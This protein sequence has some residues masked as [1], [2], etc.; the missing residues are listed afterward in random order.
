MKKIS[1]LLIGLVLSTFVLAEPSTSVLIRYHDSGQYMKDFKKIVNSASV[2]LHHQENKNI[3]KPAIVLDID[4]TSLSNWPFLE[5]TKFQYVP[6]LMDEWINLAKSPAL[7]PTL[8]LYQYAQSHHIA[9]FFI[10][11][12]FEY[13]RAATIQNLK[14]AGYQKWAGL[15]LRPD[16][17]P[18]NESVAVYKTKARRQ[19][20]QQGYTILLNMGDQYSDLCG[21]FA[22]KREKLPNPFYYLP[23]CPV[24]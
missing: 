15:Y 20:E 5:K 19:I 8:Q 9:V 24:R 12:R 14:K 2:V 11:G 18:K 7:L 10:T 16:H 6:K 13:L 3:L 17:S 23:G 21:G 1:I 22:K 4:E